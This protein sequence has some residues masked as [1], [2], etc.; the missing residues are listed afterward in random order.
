M[1]ASAA[2][3]PCRSWV[4]PIIWC[5]SFIVPQSSRHVY[6]SRPD[7]LGSSYLGVGAVML[8]LLAVWRGRK[9][10]VWLLT[11]LAIFSLLMALGSRGLV[12]DWL[13]RLLPLIGL[14]RFPI[15]FLVL[16]TFVIPL[17]AAFGLSWLQGLPAVAGRE[18]G[19][20]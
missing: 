9:Q 20:G 5:R 1:A 12:Y 16:A 2:D 13:K 10:R 8:A 7:W 19:R 3:E 11:A 18:N 6:S 17:L 4:G 14:I 15:K